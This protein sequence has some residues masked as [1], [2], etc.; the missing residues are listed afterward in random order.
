MVDRDAAKFMP[1]F[2]VFFRSTQSYF[3]A[4]PGFSSRGDALGIR[5]KLKYPL[6]S[7]ND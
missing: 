2:Q 7:G 3:D 4:F 6:S 5:V 1:A